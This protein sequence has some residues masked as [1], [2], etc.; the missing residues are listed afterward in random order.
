MSGF[1][2]YVYIGAGRPHQGLG[3]VAS[4]RE[5]VELRQEAAKRLA[6]IPADTRTL[7]Q[8]VLG[9]PLPG[10]SALDRA[11]GRNGT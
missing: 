5:N 8:R 9:D 4:W 6:Q 11:N 10:R 3:K 1:K 2:P 7:T